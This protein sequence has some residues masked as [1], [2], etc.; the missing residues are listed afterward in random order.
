MLKKCTTAAVVLTAALFGLAAAASAKDDCKKFEGNGYADNK[1]TAKEQAKV[2]VT[3][4]A[5]Q[6]AQSHAHWFKLTVKELDCKKPV[7]GVITCEAEAK[8]CETD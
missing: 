2:K 3:D 7:A 5:E 8:V 4:L 6:W 1:G